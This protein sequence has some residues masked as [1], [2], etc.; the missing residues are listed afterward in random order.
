MDGGDRFMTYGFN[1]A[2]DNHLYGGGIQTADD[3]IGMVECQECE[4]LFDEEDGLKINGLWYCYDCY[5]GAKDETRSR[6]QNLLK[7]M[8]GFEIEVFWELVDDRDV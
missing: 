1:E 2:L 3:S 4:C 5:E 7:S 8:D 6:I